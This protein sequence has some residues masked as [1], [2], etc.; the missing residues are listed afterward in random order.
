MDMRRLKRQLQTIAT[1][2]AVRGKVVVLIDEYD[3][4]LIDNLERTA[5]ARRI[6]EVLRG[7]YTVLKGVDEYLRYGRPVRRDVGYYS[8]G[9]GDRLSGLLAGLCPRRELV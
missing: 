9:V 2:L 4:P 3:K 1:A 6:Q 8:G 7:F 5:E